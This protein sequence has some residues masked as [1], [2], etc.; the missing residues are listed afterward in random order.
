MTSLAFVVDD[1]PVFAELDEVDGQRI[2]V[3][4]PYR[5]KDLIRTVPGASWSAKDS[6]WKVPL[7]WAGCLA[8]RGVFGADLGIG[9][10]LT[11]WAQDEY[12]ARVGPAVNLRTAVHLDS[13]PPAVTELPAARLVKEWREKGMSPSRKLYPYQETGAVFMSVAERGLLID[14]MGVGKTATAIA[15]L[16]VLYQTGR[17]PFPCLVV[18]PN[19][20]KINWRREV[21]AAWPGL[22]VQ[23]VK[24][25]A[26][27]RRKQLETP[28]HVYVMNWEA[29]RGHSRLAPYGS[30]ALKRCVECGGEDER[31]KHMQCQ[32]HPR[33]LN[34][35]TFHSVIGD[36]IHRMKDPRSQ[37]TRA[38]WSASGAAQY[39]IGLTGTP[40]A[41]APDDLWTILHWLS[42]AE[43]P[44]R[45]KYVDRFCELSY[46]A[47]GPMTVIGLKMHTEK[48]FFGS[49]DARMRRMPKAL[50]LPFLPPVVRV[51]KD[52][53]MTPKQQK[54][55]I[56]MRD[57]MIAELEDGA[58][59]ATTSPLT[60]STRLLQ[61]SSSY[62]ELETDEK[63]GEVETK[64]IEPSNKIDAFID[65]MADFGDAS[66]V[67]FA[68]SRK[69]I[70]LLSA[71]L[72]KLKV[73]HGLI[74]GA[75]DEDARQRHLDDFQA[76]K[77]KF[78]LCTIAAG[79]VG[80][81]LTRASVAVFLQRSWSLIDSAQAEARVHR[82]GSE[83]HESITIIDY[84]TPNTIEEQQ[85]TA[86]HAKSERLEQIA[87]DRVALLN[88]LRN[89][90]PAEGEEK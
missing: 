44:S 18:C 1:H 87:R 43:Y 65:D 2:A 17:N 30:I 46:N 48:E 24:G 27:A 84:V 57:L 7:G 40:L 71:K 90:S 89:E 3:R 53:E 86:V 56:Q 69:L 28:A 21:E 77:T 36:E 6:T 73:P 63:T 32:V 41:S 37:Q 42:P 64:L 20:V 75:Q 45:S 68:V 52:V 47:F 51:R 61:F 10:R 11:K 70:E 29:L 35:M 59:L 82:I 15:T 74:T 26:A 9:E 4:C 23:V 50:V 88:A 13:L 39:R 34:Q 38:F 16:R 19:S 85:I 5:Y 22:T 72:E 14:E 58:T 78:I 66:V 76:G 55:Y 60:K 54:A 67:V 12:A 80:L 62:A 83:V 49:V 31:I 8:L 33:E 79:G 81:T 25:S